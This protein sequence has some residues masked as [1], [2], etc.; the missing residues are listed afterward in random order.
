MQGTT[1]EG[2]LVSPMES[3]AQV[4]LY[5]PT[6]QLIGDQVLSIKKGANLIEFTNQQLNQGIYLLRLHVENEVFMHKIMVSY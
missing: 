6:G 1:I 2:V 4:Q 5:T 3:S